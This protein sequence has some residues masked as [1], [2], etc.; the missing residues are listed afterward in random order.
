MV[1]IKV[2]KC[3]TGFHDYTKRK[4]LSIVGAEM[5]RLNIVRYIQ[6]RKCKFCEKEREQY[7]ERELL[8]DINII[9]YNDF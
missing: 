1:L 9:K 4:D 7:F 6:I 3:L 5:H 2:I 8:G